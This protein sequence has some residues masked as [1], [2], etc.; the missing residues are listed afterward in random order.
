VG[1]EREAAAVRERLLRRDV[2]LLTLTGSGG[3]GKTRLALQ[4]AAGLLDTFEHGVFFVA[5]D[6]V[7]DAALVAS[8]IVQVLGVPPAP[9]RSPQDTLVEHLREKDLLLVLDNFEQVV[10]AGPDLAALVAL[11]PRLKVLVT[12]REPLRVRAE[13]ESSVPALALPDRSLVA[14]LARGD[15]H[16]D[17]L[18]QIAQSEA[19]R[20]FVDRARAVGAEI[21]VARENAPAIAEVCHRLDGLP[22]AIELAAARAKVLP[23]PALLA[24]LAATGGLPLLTRGARD[25]PARQ[26]TLRSA[27]AWSYELLT[28]EEQALFRR[29]VVFQGGWTLAAA[30][31]VSGESAADV[32][33]ELASLVDKGLVRRSEDAARD[34]EPRYTMLQTIQEFALEQLHASGE[35]EATRRRHAAYCADIAER[36]EPMLAGVGTLGAGATVAPP[37]ALAANLAN[38]RAA[39]AY[40][41]AVGD[42]E[43]ALGLAVTLEDLWGEFS[44]APQGVESFRRIV[45]AAE[46]VPNPPPRLLSWLA[47]AYASPAVFS[48]LGFDSGEGIA[49]AARA[50]TL[51]RQTADP[52][53]MAAADYISALAHWWGGDAPGGAPFSA[54]AVATYREMGDSAGILRALQVYAHIL[55]IEG[56]ASA[57]QEALEE[58]ARLARRQED[59]VALAN[60]VHE[61]GSVVAYTGDDDRA[62]AHFEEA[63]AIR[64]RLG[65]ANLGMSLGAL[66]MLAG[67]RG[68]NATAGHLLRGALAALAPPERPLNLGLILGHGTLPLEGLAVVA[69]RAGDL[70]RAARLSAAVDAMGGAGYA[71]STFATRY[72]F[73]RLRAMRDAELQQLSPAQHAAWETALAESAAFDPNDRAILEALLRFA[74]AP[75]AVEPREEPRRGKD[76]NGLTAREAE[77]L[78]LVTQGMTDRQIAAELVISEKTVGR[79]LEH[80]FNKLGVS[81][82]TAAAVAYR[83][84]SR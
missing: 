13:H 53:T 29:L 83:D 41:V 12:S 18:D 49:W 5:L 80:V 35:A 34:G 38:F 17:A 44:S 3:I 40:L 30:E 26:R 4:V 32:L 78:R 25:A 72:R 8:S 65:S 19:V 84:T 62:W 39:L 76:V 66:G 27:I 37:H 64:R 60:Y 6:A 21:E 46:G 7:R 20:L 58:G 79:H 73:G 61:L 74:R 68:D 75:D 67:A 69:L 11:C 14:A 45:A 57:A 81:S 9:G 56:Q 28:T 47:R 82:R 33:D 22:L 48:A 42:H 54:R 70:R 23:P 2:R 43:G 50:R 63:A 52:R 1:R 77:V 31:A 71:A 55:L 10:A 59:A 16:G 24:R 15:A 51:S 36:A